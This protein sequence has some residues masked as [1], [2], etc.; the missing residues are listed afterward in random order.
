MSATVPPAAA[1]TRRMFSWRLGELGCEVRPHRL[2]VRVP[3]DLAREIDGL[4][5][6]GHDGVAEA[7]GEIVRHVVRVDVR[8]LGHWD[9]PSLAAARRAPQ[10]VSCSASASSA[11][12]VSRILNFWILPVT[13]IGNS[14]TKRT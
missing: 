4:A 9:S 10:A 12:I 11:I 3:A 8:E 14:S 1:S 2:A 6:F 7:V 5:A 13:V